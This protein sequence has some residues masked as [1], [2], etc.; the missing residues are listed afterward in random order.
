M[1]G[2]DG[3]GGTSRPKVAV[4]HIRVTMRHGR[5]IP[6]QCWSLPQDTLLQWNC[7]YPLTPSQ[8]KSPG[9]SGQHPS[10]LGHHDGPE[11][12]A[13]QS[14]A[15]RRLTAWVGREELRDTSPGHGS[16]VTV[17]AGATP[18]TWQEKDKTFC[19][20]KKS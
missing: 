3:S 9:A 6:V 17:R 10:L 11:Q 4:H 14:H 2:A 15:M 12:A 18:Q 7:Q 19:Q 20:G 16:P 5:D 8:E 13:G 1:P